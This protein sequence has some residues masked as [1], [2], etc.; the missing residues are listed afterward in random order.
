MNEQ[1]ILVIGNGASLRDSNL[2]NKIDELE[3][4]RILISDMANHQFD[5]SSPVEIVP[6]DYDPNLRLPDPK[7]ISR[8]RWNDHVPP[9]TIENIARIPNWSKFDRIM[10]N[11][12]SLAFEEMKQINLSNRERAREFMI[13]EIYIASIWIYLELKNLKGNNGEISDVKLEAF[14]MAMR[15]VRKLLLTNIK[16]LIR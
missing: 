11:I 9:F 13:K 8:D 4:I 12:D 1:S 14:D 3:D 10:I 15:G 2:G 16:K 5:I 6:P 7:I